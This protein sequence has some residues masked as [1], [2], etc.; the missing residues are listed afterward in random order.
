[1]SF[2]CKILAN[3]HAREEVED[4]ITAASCGAAVRRDGMDILRFMIGNSHCPPYST[5]PPAL[6]LAAVVAYPSIP[7]ASAQ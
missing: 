3:S 4:S 5:N 2:T 7:R 6:F 1:M